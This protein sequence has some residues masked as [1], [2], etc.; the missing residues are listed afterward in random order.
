M[1]RAVIRAAVTGI[2]P[3]TPAR[4][5][6]SSY[7]ARPQPMPR[8]GVKGIT[9]RQS[10]KGIHTQIVSKS[11]LTITSTTASAISMG[12]GKEVGRPPAE[13]PS[14]PPYSERDAQSEAPPAYDEALSEQAIHT[15]TQYP[16][17]PSVVNLYG[18]RFR[19][20]SADLCGDDARQRLFQVDFHTGVIATG[21][22]GPRPGIVLRKGPSSKAPVAGAAGW[23]SASAATS[24]SCAPDSI[25]VPAQLGSGCERQSCRRNDARHDNVHGDLLF[26]FKVE[27]GEKQ[28]RREFA[29]V[30]LDG[31]GGGESST[32]QHRFR[33]VQQSP[34]P[35]GKD[36][37]GSDGS[38]SSSSKIEPGTL[39]MLSFY[40]TPAHT[41]HYFRLELTGVDL[42]PR[43]AL[44][45]VLTALRLWMLRVNL[46]N[47][48]GEALFGPKRNA[49]KHAH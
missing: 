9:S 29:W 38:S 1:P 28:A 20:L 44:M 45:T 2:K 42:G 12:K 14:P 16:R 47:A 23:A 21:P 49:T 32:K 26:C 37:K 48:P 39:A 3:P 4:T 43:W 24:C 17:F 41:L 5:V 30:K 35:W 25:V 36:G 13:G 15:P 31:G 46:Q 33:L 6:R 8:H 34:S 10:R 40:P 22:L 11:T 27:A 7:I 18:S 19:W